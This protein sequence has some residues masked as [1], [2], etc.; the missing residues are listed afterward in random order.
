MTLEEPPGVCFNAGALLPRVSV[1]STVRDLLAAKGSTVLAIGPRATVLEAAMRMN[2]RKIGSLAVVEGSTLVGIIT[3]RDLLSRVIVQRRDP[4]T[5]LVQHVMTAEVL[6]C[7]PD[8]SL[9]EVR[10]MMKSRRIRH[11]P[12][13]EADELVGLVSIGDLNAHAA[14]DRELT[15]HEMEEYIAG[16]V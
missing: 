11:V 6:C 3:E 15:I 13:L 16:R 1:M 14:C 5:T 7:E 9:D 2:E 12:V 10:L 8:C 4:V